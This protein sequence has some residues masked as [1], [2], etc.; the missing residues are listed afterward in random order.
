MFM[1]HILKCSVCGSYG[2]EEICS[3]GAK[4]EKVAPAKFSPEDKYAEYRRKAKEEQK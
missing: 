2:L 3:C 1:A 4:R